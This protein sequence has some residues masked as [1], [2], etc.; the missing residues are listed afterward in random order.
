[1][2]WPDP[3]VAAMPSRGPFKHSPFNFKA[4]WMKAHAL[5]EEPWVEEAEAFARADRIGEVVLFDPRSSAPMP[6][7]CTRR[8]ASEVLVRL[9]VREQ[10]QAAAVVWR[11][12]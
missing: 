5:T 6:E 3:V 9:H 11:E 8:F 1:M 7:H 12:F 4:V 10:P 2:M